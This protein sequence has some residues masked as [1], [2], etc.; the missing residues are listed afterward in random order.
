MYKCA[1]PF[2]VQKKIYSLL[3]KIYAI[4]RKDVSQIIVS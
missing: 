3:K 4:L 1:S 2:D